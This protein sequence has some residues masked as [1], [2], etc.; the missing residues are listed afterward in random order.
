VTTGPTSA[1]PK[2]RLGRLVMLFSRSIDRFDDLEGFR[3]GA[4]FSYYATFAIFPLALLTLT[5]IGYVVGDSDAIRDR[6]LTSV[7]SSDSS[8]TDVIGQTLASMRNG[9][10]R[11]TSAVVGLI[12]LF[13][14]ASGAFVELDFALNKIWRVEPRVGKGIIGKVR[15]FLAERLYGLACVMGIGLFLVLSLVT[16]SA[17]SL[18]A[19]HAHTALSLAFAWAA[20]L[21]VSL[22]LLSLALAAT[23]HF[24]PRSRPPFR[25]VI[26]GAVL[27]TVL[28]T[29]L[30]ALFALYLAHLT[31]Y[32]AYGVAGGVL[33]L[34]TWI[35]LS[36]Q[37][38]FF[39][40][41][42]TRVHCEMTD[43]PA[44]KSKEEGNAGRGA[45]EMETTHATAE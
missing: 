3:L 22:V 19:S 5:L 18:V 40:A 33:A 27:T 24:V 17:L 15:V 45:V 13:F 29:V 26:G 9:S 44:A 28:L 38:I 10:A 32:S 25:N 1:L 30:K 16:G 20:E 23:F 12:S 37:V 42:L 11:K 41:T 8:V 6:L 14:S 21:G 36:S 4:A 39:G 7:A 31:S 34:A 2:T 43:C 35:Y